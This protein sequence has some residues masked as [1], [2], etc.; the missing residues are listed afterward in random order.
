MKALLLIASLLLIVSYSQAAHSCFV[1][2]VLSIE[3]TKSCSE[4]FEIARACAMGSSKDIETVGAA[5]SVCDAEY[6]GREALK[7]SDKFLYQ[8]LIV[9]CSEAFQGKEGT[10]YQSLAAFCKLDAAK[11]INSIKLSESL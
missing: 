9:R 6:G 11:F 5:I 4:A 2:P 8:A 7:E 3:Q 10:M 1:E